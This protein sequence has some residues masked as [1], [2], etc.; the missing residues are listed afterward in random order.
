MTALT[1]DEMTFALR[2]VPHLE[3]GL[4]FE[5]AGHAVLDDD[6][7]LTNAAL[8]SDG[9]L[10]IQ[11]YDGAKS[12]STGAGRMGADIRCQLSRTVYNR[13]RAA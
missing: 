8:A 10:A 11:T 2:M 12:C 1:K 7:R 6:M 13:L 9:H 4:S 5:E 3:R